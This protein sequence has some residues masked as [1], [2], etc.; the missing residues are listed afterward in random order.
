MK[1]RTNVLPRQDIYSIHTSW[2]M[3]IVQSN[4]EPS[5]PNRMKC[6]M[7]N[8]EPFGRQIDLKMSPHHH[9]PP[10][11][12][13]ILP[14]RNSRQNILQVRDI[15]DGN[16]Y[17]KRFP[18]QDVAK[19]RDIMVFYEHRNAPRVQRFHHPRARHFITT[20]AN[21]EPALPHHCWIRHTFWEIFVNLN[22]RIFVLPMF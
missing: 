13:Y 11:H 7:K 8:I 15:L 1:Q 14:S 5:E 4:I 12:S 19:R 6:H 22:F 10:L 9:S 20:R 21:A 16:F 2:I 3:N 18:V 17:S